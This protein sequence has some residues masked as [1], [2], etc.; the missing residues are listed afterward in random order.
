[1]TAPEREQEKR[2]NGELTQLNK[3]IIERSRSPVPD[4]NELAKLRE[5]LQAVRTAYETFRVTLYAAHPEL[6][7]KQAEFIPFSLK[8][9]QNFLPDS[10]AALLEYAVGT[11]CTY[12]F[13]LTRSAEARSIERAAAPGV[14]LRVYR[15]DIDAEKLRAKVDSYRQRVSE[16]SQQY[17]G[18]AQ[19]LYELLLSP[20]RA[21]LQ[22]RT[23]LTVVPDG[24]LW[25]LPFQAL[26]SPENR[27]VIEDYALAYAPS[28]SVLRAIQENSSRRRPRAAAHARPDTGRTDQKDDAGLDLLAMGNPKLGGDEVIANRAALRGGTLE[29]L[30]AAEKEVQAIAR[31]R[32]PAGNA[33]V[34]IRQWATEERFKLLAPNARIIHIATHGILDD[35]NPMYSYLV[36][37]SSQQKDDGLLEAWE[38]MN[39]DLHAELAVL[40]ACETARGSTESGEGVIGMTW[41][42]FMAGCPTTAVSL[43]K[44]ESEST[45]QLMVEFHH[46]LNRSAVRHS[47]LHAAEALRRAQLSLLRQESLKHPF[48][49]AGF[50]IIGDGR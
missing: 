5:Q 26:R 27:Y 40:S 4:Q 46:N 47:P 28:L 7:T 6:R 15:L 17:R 16:G 8:E 31:L 11:D 3:S 37:A 22:G 48:Y 24:V 10:N 1:M 32:S 50:V 19:E 13:V 34:Y 42:L 35:R 41:A 33:K 44:V 25:S 43:W 23:S 39:L 9:A 20:A 49:W 30:P 36:L 12:L 2:L 14:D 18:L 45:R 38:V 29:P 21:Q